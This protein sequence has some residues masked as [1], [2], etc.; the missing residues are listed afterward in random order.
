MIPTSAPDGFTTLGWRRYLL[1]D[2]IT[3]AAPA[4]LGSLAQALLWTLDPQTRGE[5][6]LLVWA[7]AALLLLSPA[8]TW[9]GLALA[10][11]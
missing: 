1:A 8:F 11:P 9:F 6:W 7:L 5:A 3:L 2:L 10:A 4:A